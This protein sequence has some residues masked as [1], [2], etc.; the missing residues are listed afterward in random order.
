M[1]E[2]QID[3]ATLERLL[4]TRFSARK[5]QPRAVPRATLDQILQ[6]AQRT[7]SWCNIQPW[8]V[9]LVSGEPLNELRERM[10][11]HARG[12]APASPDFPFPP[13]Y[14]ASHR[15]RR[16]VCGLQLYQSLGIG[17]EDRAAAAEQSL[18]NYRMFGAPHLA[19]IFVD[20]YLGF[21]G[22][23][24][25]GLYAMT[26]MLAAHSLG[27]DTIAQASLASYPEL[28]RQQ[29]ALPPSRKLVCGIAIGYAE[30]EHPINN[31]RTERAAVVEAVQFVE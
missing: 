21:Y 31:Y 14:T 8:Q 30:R 18:E 3:A 29:L 22:A 20:D 10:W 5:F 9:V 24:D 7:P 2:Q 4:R 23:L 15:D 25:C 6:L 12:G 1:S 16:K 19:L 11:Q 26:L 27:V 17:K 28:V 13:N